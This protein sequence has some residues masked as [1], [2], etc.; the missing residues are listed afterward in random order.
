MHPS[1]IRLPKTDCCWCNSL[2]VW[3]LLDA[4][5]H[6]QC[7]FPD[8][9]RCL[10]AIFESC[11]L[12]I[13]LE[14][15]KYWKH[16]HHSERDTDATF[17]HSHSRSFIKHTKCSRAWGKEVQ[18]QGG[19]L[20]RPRGACRTCYRRT[21]PCRSRCEGK[22]KSNFQMLYSRSASVGCDLGQN[23][24]AEWLAVPCLR[25]G[26]NE[27]QCAGEMCVSSRRNEMQMLWTRIFG[28]TTWKCCR[29]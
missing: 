27:K 2:T 6:I 23:T 18:I 14:T 19:W 29:W 9:R 20:D 17:I 7:F 8:S 11:T 16:Q 12:R 24:L 15:F 4:N 13:S 28:N 21:S 22:R 26:L 5:L 10:S 1:Q 25:P 3:M